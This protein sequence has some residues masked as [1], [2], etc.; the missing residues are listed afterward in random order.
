MKF[1]KITPEF[2]TVTLDYSKEYIR[3][4][5]KSKLTKKCWCKILRITPT[6]HQN[7]MHGKCAVSRILV[8]SAHSLTYHVT[9]C[10]KSY[11]G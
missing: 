9:R 5:Q 10:L 1:E 7:I 6:E 2:K 8:N 4:Y 3:L 11:R